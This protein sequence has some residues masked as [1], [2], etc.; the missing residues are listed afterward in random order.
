M[1]AEQQAAIVLRQG[2]DIELVKAWVEGL[3]SSKHKNPEY[4]DAFLT[5]IADKVPSVRAEYANGAEAK[6]LLEVQ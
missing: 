3:V 4:V 1:T 6:A 2:Q 5:A